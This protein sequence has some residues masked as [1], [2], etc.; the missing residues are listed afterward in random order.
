MSDAPIDRSTLGRDQRLQRGGDFARIK[1]KGQRRVRGCLILNWIENSDIARP[2][3]GVITSKKLGNAVRRSRAR[4]LMRE[5]FRL[6]QFELRQ[7]IDLILVA[8]RSI[9]EL[10]RP[11]VEEVFLKLARDSGL[12]IDAKS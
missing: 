10:T 1:S 4:R 5:A 11:D 9:N 12:I 3:L 6:H 2:R 7:D 8:R